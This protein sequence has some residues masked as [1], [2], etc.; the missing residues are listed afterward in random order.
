MPYHKLDPAR[1]HETVARLQT[2]VE[3]RFPQRG[4]AQVAVQL[5]ALARE[6]GPRAR[7]IARGNGVRR[8]LA[9]LLA[10]LLLL[11]LV[12]LGFQTVHD[13]GVTDLATFLQTLEAGLASIVFLG[14][15]C[16]SVVTFDARRART[17]ILRA[18]DEI[19]SMAHVVDMHQLAKSP[20]KL[21]LPGANTPSSPAMDDDPFL[22]GRYLDY[23]SEMLSLMS[24]I[25]AVYVRDSDDPVAL[26]AADEIESLTSALSSKIWQK[27]ALLS[28]VPGAPASRA[29]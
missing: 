10:S 13:D 12:A 9:L 21:I 3:E 11:G 17:R 18:L 5:T 23:C 14:A 27:I 22:L 1:I 28:Q 15:A 16:L 24:K 8:V 19:R 6:A 26:S 25:A 20:E 29:G 7:K 2:R 4:L